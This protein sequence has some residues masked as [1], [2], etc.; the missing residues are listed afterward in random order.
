MCVRRPVFKSVTVIG[1]AVLLFLAPI[2]VQA[3]E[4]WRKLMKLYGTEIPKT[5]EIV[6]LKMA[7]VNIASSPDQLQIISGT[8]TKVCRKKG[9]W[10]ILSDKGSHARITFKDY[11]FFVPPKTGRVKSI[12]Y[13]K[14]I[15]TKGLGHHRILKDSEVINNCLKFVTENNNENQNSLSAKKYTVFM[16][17][18]G[19]FDLFKITQQQTMSNSLKHL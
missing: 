14:L 13:G 16:D 2:T 4:D 19:A 5:G 9:C 12:V 17:M 10:M 1:L 7:I 15:E 18:E 11:E 3:A 6:S 8:V